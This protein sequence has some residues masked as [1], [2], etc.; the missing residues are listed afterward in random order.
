MHSLLI[1]DFT[2]HILWKLYLSN[3]CWSDLN[4]INLIKKLMEISWALSWYFTRAYL[5]MC[6]FLYFIDFTVYMLLQLYLSK[7]GSI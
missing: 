5:H 7:S 1:N 6:I 4:E 3:I 2:V